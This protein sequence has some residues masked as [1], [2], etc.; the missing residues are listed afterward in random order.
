MFSKKRKAK[1]ASIPLKPEIAEA[2]ATAHSRLATKLSKEGK[3]ASARYQAELAH[4]IFKHHQEPDSKQR[5]AIYEKS[6]GITRT[7]FKK[8]KGKGYDVFPPG[9]PEGPSVLK[10]VSIVVCPDKWSLRFP[11]MKDALNYVRVNNVGD[12][13]VRVHKKP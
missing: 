1:I 7:P 12:L 2:R 9:G 4:Y 6:Q 8:G 11:S 13:P 10:G 5:R 3:I